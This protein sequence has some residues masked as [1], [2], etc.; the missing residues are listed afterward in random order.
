MSNQIT[1]Y[2][3]LLEVN[4]IN[5]TKLSKIDSRQI[6]RVLDVD[7]KKDVCI[8]ESKD[9]TTTSMPVQIKTLLKSIQ[10]GMIALSN[11]S[12]FSNYTFKR[13]SK[14]TN[15]C[16][17]EIKN[18]GL[19]INNN[20]VTSMDKVYKNL[21]AENDNYICMGIHAENPGCYKYLDKVLLIEKRTG[22]YEF[23]NVSK[24]IGDQRHFDEESKLIKVA[25]S[26]DNFIVA[27]SIA[28]AIV[29]P[30]VLFDESLKEGDIV[31]PK[32]DMSKPETYFNYEVCTD[33][34][35]II[36][37]KKEVPKAQ[38]LRLPGFNMTYDTFKFSGAIINYGQSSLMFVDST[39]G[40]SWSVSYGHST[41]MTTDEVWKCKNFLVNCMLKAIPTHRKLRDTAVMQKVN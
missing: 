5:K 7:F 1:T 41:T 11:P 12:V 18:D 28:K 3:E 36:T 21:R 17:I 27:S 37:L 23:V 30:Y 10:D 6:K 20:L 31:K 15:T 32:L 35:V 40:Q 19:Y 2:Q 34:D 14:P 4:K 26:G 39:T 22:K 13:Q 38:L 33:E 8:I 29:Y 16:N 24:V 25:C 9:K